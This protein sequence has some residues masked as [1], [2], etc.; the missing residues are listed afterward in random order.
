MENKCPWLIN[1][2]HNC[3]LASAG[4]VSIYSGF[5]MS[6]MRDRRASFRGIP[7]DHIYP[8]MQIESLLADIGLFCEFLHCDLLHRF[9]GTQFD[10][11]AE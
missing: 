6:P 8:E 11:C 1:A 2:L 5:G 10:K 9:G 7:T 3:L 4:L